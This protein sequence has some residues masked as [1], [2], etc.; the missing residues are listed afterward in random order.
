MSKI[1]LIDV[2][3]NN[4]NIT[5]DVENPIIKGKKNRGESYL[6]EIAFKEVKKYL[7][8]SEV[9]L[10]PDENKGVGFWQVI[11]GGFRHVGDIKIII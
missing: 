1:I 11:V 4:I 8:S 6:A 7:A 3:R 9:N 5:I 10:I 2:G